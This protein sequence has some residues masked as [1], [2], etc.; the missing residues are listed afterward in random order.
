MSEN[1]KKP[2]KP[3]PVPGLNLDAKEFVPRLACSCSGPNRPCR[4]VDSCNN[5]TCWFSHGG[6]CK[7]CKLFKQPIVAP[8]ASAS[9]PAAALPEMTEEDHKLNMHSDAFAAAEQE[10]FKE[11]EEK[12][13]IV[14]YSPWDEE[15]YNLDNDDWQSDYEYDEEKDH[16]DQRIATLKGAQTFGLRLMAAAAACRR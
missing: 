9:A 11:E 15:D 1:P 13:M 5:D 8:A 14:A 12:G 4:H 7:K 6:W 2:K 3:A 16:I 10:A